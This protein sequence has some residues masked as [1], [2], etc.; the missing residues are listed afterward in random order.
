MV[1][2]HAAGCGGDV[3]SHGIEKRAVDVEGYAILKPVETVFV[4]HAVW[5]ERK[6]FDHVAGRVDGVVALSNGFGGLKHKVD[7][8]LGS[9]E[10]AREKFHVDFL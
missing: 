4:E 8:P 9:I 3:N 7:G 5:V 6:A 1:D 2:E 10:F